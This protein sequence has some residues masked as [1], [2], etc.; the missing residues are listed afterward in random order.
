MFSPTLLEMILII[1]RTARHQNIQFFVASVN[2]IQK[3]A[4]DQGNDGEDSQACGRNRGCRMNHPAVSGKF[5]E[6]VPSKN[7]TQ[8]EEKDR[9]REK[10]GKGFVI[11]ENIKYGQS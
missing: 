4:C 6:G 7:K 1:R 9:D 5:M 8:E 10:K 3:N 2:R 11:L